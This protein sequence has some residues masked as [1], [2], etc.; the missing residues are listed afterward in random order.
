MTQTLSITC[1]DVKDDA[2]AYALKFG[3]KVMIAQ[4]L[5]CAIYRI[6]DIGAIE[7]A[8]PTRMGAARYMAYTAPYAGSWVGSRNIAALVRWIDERG[9][10]VEGK[11]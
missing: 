3:E 8:A 7:V 5:G 1:L 9:A 6:G 10:T 4:H 2:G 11:K